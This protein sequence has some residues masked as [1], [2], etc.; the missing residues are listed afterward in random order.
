MNSLTSSSTY[1]A[2][3]FIVEVVELEREASFSADDLFGH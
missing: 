3:I 2:R 1:Y